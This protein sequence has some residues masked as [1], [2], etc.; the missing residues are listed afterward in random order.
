MI[1]YA[2]IPG[3]DTQKPHRG[4]EEAAGFDVF[5]PYI[6]D[7][8]RDEFKKKNNK[9]GL[10]FIDFDTDRKEY[11]KIPSHSRVV[12]PTGLRFNIN[13]GEY[14]E[15]ANRGSMAAKDGL[16]FGAHII[17]S[18]Y[19]GEVFINLINTTDAPARL[20]FGQKIAQILHKE[21]LM[22]ELEESDNDKLYPEASKRGAGALGSTGK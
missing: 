19:Q 8:M 6:N 18:D 4:S 14:L 9:L 11:I 3:F 17:D 20:D 5:V 10:A 13:H 15:V 16:I 22:S 12:V 21:V 1:K 7:V 2:V